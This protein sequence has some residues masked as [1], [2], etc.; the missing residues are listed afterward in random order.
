ME[1]VLVKKILK[2]QDLSDKF[3]DL[4]NYSATMYYFRNEECAKNS[5][6]QTSKIVFFKWFKKLDQC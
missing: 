1:S 4:P 2:L 6:F 5:T 3:L